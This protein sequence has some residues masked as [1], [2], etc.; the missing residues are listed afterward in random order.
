VNLKRKT[1]VFLALCA[2]ASHT[3]VLANENPESTLSAL[4]TAA[5]K[6]LG[7]KTANDENA[8]E[9]P[10]NPGEPP[11]FYDNVVQEAKKLS[12]QP[13]VQ[14]PKDS[15]KPLTKVDYSQYRAIRFNTE[16]SLWREQSPFEIQFFHPGFLYQDPLTINTLENGLASTVNFDRG[17]FR[18]DG[19]AAPLAETPLPSNNF[20]GFRVHY[21]LNSGKYKDEFMV[22][23]GASYFRLVGPGHA[24]GLSARG[25]AIDT[26]EPTGEE[27][28]YFRE[29]WLQKPGPNDTSMQIYALLDS[30]SV[31]GAFKFDVKPGRR[32][33]VDVEGTVFARKDIKKLGIAPL[34]SMFVFGETSV[35]HHDDYRPEVHDSDG[36]QILSGAG[37]WIWRPLQNP[38]NLHVS[39][40]QDK[41]PKGFGLMQR[42][43]EF[44]HYLDVEA[45][46]HQRPSFWVEPIGKWGKGAIE[47]VEIPTDSETNDNIVAYWVPAKPLLA[48][49]KKRFKYRIKVLNDIP[50]NAN[51]G[52]V[53][54]HK[55]GWAALPGEAN[56]PAKTKR[57]FVVDFYSG[58]LE[59]LSHDMA[60]T[61]SLTTSSGKVSDLMLQKIPGLERWRAYFKL[62]PEGNKP[63]DMRLNLLLNGKPI[64]ET[65]TYVW[66]PES[67]PKSK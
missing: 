36:L 5:A 66:Y 3:T 56:P 47:L 51:L 18:Y 10:K 58:D 22:F 39:A 38:V 28:P 52:R 31:T 12:L 17:L 11:T 43:R 23:Q 44:D 24:Y 62:E 14:P 13:F 63:A 7:V 33:E 30:P 19:P 35:V 46:Y 6:A 34:T 53:L 20:A 1:S 64:T 2:L 40:M 45:H 25:L 50:P 26:A 27:F 29:F 9:P 37:E 42:D 15:S 67:L 59:G 41:S 61:P 55:N 57:L 48:K 54:Y 8:E 65:W 21:S 60:V 49:Q 4:K 32:V 16:K